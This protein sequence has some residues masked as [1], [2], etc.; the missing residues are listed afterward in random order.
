MLSKHKNHQLVKLPNLNLANYFI[1][2]A[3][4]SE[5]EEYQQLLPKDERNCFSNLGRVSKT[6]GDEKAGWRCCC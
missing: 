5:E 3:L 1:E 4:A 6:H 2:P